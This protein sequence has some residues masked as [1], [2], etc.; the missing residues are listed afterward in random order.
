MPAST[1]EQEVGSLPW[2]TDESIADR[3]GRD[4]VRV[5]EQPQV[6]YLSSPTHAD[7]GTG[8]SGPTAAPL[9]DAG[10]LHTSGSAQ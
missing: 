6:P 8:L 3:R 5:A 4:T 1:N 2:L 9:Y 7:P 10:Q